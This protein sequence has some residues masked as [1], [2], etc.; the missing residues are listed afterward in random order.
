MLIHSATLYQEYAQ[1]PKSQQK[2]TLSF[3]FLYN[4]PKSVFSRHKNII[5]KNVINTYQATKYYK[6]FYASYVWSEWIAL[7]P[8]MHPN[9]QTEN[10][11]RTEEQNDGINKKSFITK[12]GFNGILHIF[13]RFK[14][15]QSFF[16]C[17]FL[18]YML[19]PEERSYLLIIRFY[20][21]SYKSNH[22]SQILL[23]LKPK[24]KLIFAMAG[25][26]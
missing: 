12:T 24:L 5:I 23:L 2:Y 4:F 11:T 19:L 22:I 20:S 6:S 14:S 15:W 18:W 3:T 9:P 17:R 7:F 10:E 26:A 8:F 21:S 16:R 25:W 1:I 13:F